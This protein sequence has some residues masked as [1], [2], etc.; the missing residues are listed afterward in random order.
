MVSTPRFSF[1]LRAAVPLASMVLG[2]AVSAAQAQP[3]PQPMRPSAHSSALQD[4]TAPSPPPSGA[5]AQRSGVTEILVLTGTAAYRERIAMPADAVLTVQLQ[6]IS[7]AD[8][9]AQVVAQTQQ[10]FGDLQV[11]LTFRME[12]P[13]AALEPRMRYALRA[14]VHAEGELRFTTTQVYPVPVHVQVQMQQGAA[15]SGTQP[16]PFNLLMQAVPAR[17]ASTDAGAGTLAG[18]VSHGSASGAASADGVAEPGM[19]HLQDT[20]WKLVALD[21]QPTPML[22]GQEREVRIT[23]GSAN[24][25]V[26]GFGGC[27]GMGGSYTLD[28]AALKFDQ[29]ASTR[30]MCAPAANALER[31]VLGALQTT[32][33]FRIRGEQLMLLGSGRVLARFEAVYMH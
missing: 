26:Q 30:K 20:Y 22:P 7:R 27:N 33:H 6:N 11:P 4:Q 9:P 25:Q 12:V 18:L 10:P 32:S 24:R 5:S 17:T 2:M 14:T 31:K 8:A 16:P 1:R 13:R 29:L 19:A 15:A 23:L 28:G 3:A 21:G